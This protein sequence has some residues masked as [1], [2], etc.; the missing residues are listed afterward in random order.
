[1]KLRTRT[2]LSVV[3]SLVSLVAI[4]YSVARVSMMRSFAALEA[5]DTRQ[6]LERA[7]AVLAD[8]LSTLDHTATDYADWDDTCAFVEGKN[9]TL[10]TSEFPDEW[11][12]RLRIDFVMIFDAHGRQ[13]F[14]KAYNSA[15]RKETEMPQ[16]LRAHLAPGSLLMRHA[17]PESK[18]LG[19][20]LLTS[21]AVLIDSQPIL[22]SKS[23]GPIRGTFVTGRN[24]DATEI[25]R[26]AGISHLSLTIHRLDASGLPS[27]VES[28]RGAL[29]AS[30]PT[31]LRSL[32]SKDVAGYGL[33]EDIYGKDNLI[34]RVV[35]S[36]KMALPAI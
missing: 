28:A 6:N 2:L 32:N 17:Y 19:I 1:M 35:M 29:I 31:L 36:R 12:P 4:L 23:R 10:P 3:F 30:S 26:L 25:A 24:L 15:T 22:D 5:D 21:G 16:G 9:R 8:D 27:D 13:L 14:A 33:V 18:V 11:F 34:L 7:T 20:V